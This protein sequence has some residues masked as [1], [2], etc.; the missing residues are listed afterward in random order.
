MSVQA[1]ESN[2]APL[3][4]ASAAAEPAE[5]GALLVDKLAH[6]ASVDGSLAALTAREFAL[7]VYFT[8]HAGLRLTRGQILTDVWGQYYS[9]SPRTVDIHISR[10]RR[11]LGAA[12]GLETLRRV[13]YRFGSRAK[14]ALAAS[15]TEP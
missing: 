3:P 12:L 5:P 1:V 4:A 10:L 8:E 2:V 7:L 11:K 6:T 14:L 9:G 13:G 15:G